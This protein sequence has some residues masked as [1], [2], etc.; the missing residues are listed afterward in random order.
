MQVMQVLVHYFQTGHISGGIKNICYTDRG[1]GA[2]KSD[3]TLSLS[4][5]FPDL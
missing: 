3:C 4:L 2:D 5:W 1:S